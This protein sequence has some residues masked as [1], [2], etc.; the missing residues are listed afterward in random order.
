M[1][2]LVFMLVMSVM[3]YSYGDKVAFINAKI[4]DGIFTLKESAFLV[5]NGRFAAI[6]DNKYI[7]S[8]SDKVIDLENKFVMPGFIDAHA[9]IYSLGRSLNIISLKNY[10]LEKI[11]ETINN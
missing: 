9:H 3:N 4:F 10:S 8:L 6:G 5:Q 1:K 7:T 2:Y 11:L